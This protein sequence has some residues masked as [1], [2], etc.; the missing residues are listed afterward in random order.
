MHSP[1]LADSAT[2]Q[3]RRGLRPTRVGPWHPL[4]LDQEI[5]MTRVFSCL[6]LAALLLAAQSALPCEA[7]GYRTYVSGTGSGTTCDRD[8]PC[9]DVSTAVHATFP[10]GEVR[11]L[12]GGPSNVLSGALIDKTIIIDCPFAIWG[13]V[14]NAPGI[15]VTLRNLV[16]SSFNE[17]S[18]PGIDFQNGA[19]LI[20]DHCL[21]ENWNAS[22]VIGG[23]GPGIGI[24]FAPPDGVTASLHVSDSVIVGNG[25]AASGG[26]IIVQPTGSGSAR[27]L[28]ERTRVENNTYGIF[29]NGMGST[30]LIS[31]QVRD[32]VV[33]NSVANG[34]TA[35]TSAGH[36]IASLVI[37]RSSALLSGGSGISSQGANGF[38]FVTDSTVMSNVTGLSATS[39]GAIFSYQNNRLTGNVS[40]GT[41][42]AALAVK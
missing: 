17:A 36:S 19:S 32:S 24:R 12:D 31:V 25:L 30:G 41:P 15:N 18:L 28:I 35:F 21:V 8:T 37:D 6:A 27:V 10:G 26:G 22:H 2:P 16:V 29:A 14:V 33:A 42:T 1:L 3:F 20:L 34:I 39:G 7:G 23:P 13:V 5:S 11:C 40:D 4:H 9:A 38:V